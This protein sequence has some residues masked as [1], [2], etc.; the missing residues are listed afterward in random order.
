[1]GKNDLSAC[2]DQ[3]LWRMF[4]LGCYNSMPGGSIFTGP[5]DLA[6]MLKLLFLIVVC[7][8]VYET[9]GVVAFGL[10]SIHGIAGSS[11]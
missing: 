11:E 9:I 7:L 10:P 6:T 8:F 5:Y 3:Q 2:G 1:M 4:K